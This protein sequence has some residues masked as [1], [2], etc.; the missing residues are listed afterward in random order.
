MLGGTI[1]VESEEGKG[2]TF[3]FT[4]PYQMPK[5]EK[6]YS[7][8]IA[9]V[10]APA[11]QI[12]GLK[13]IIAEDDPT[14]EMLISM[15]LKVY[16]K[17]LIKAKTGVDAVEKCRANPDVDLIMMDIKM[18]VLNGY[19]ATRQI[20]GFNKDVI[21]IAQTAYALIH[22]KEVALEAGCNDYISKP[23]SVE[24]LKSLVQKYFGT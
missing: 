16:S 2:T 14:S 23:I 1:E 13:I 4:L 24:L 19:D 17:E 21:I 5:E 10:T 20:R 11:N 7:A 22:E 12:H 18:P 6:L 3:F 9:T 8:P 15:A